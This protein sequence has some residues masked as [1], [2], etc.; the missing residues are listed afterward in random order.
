MNE[1]DLELEAEFDQNLMF[2]MIREPG[3]GTAG[4]GGDSNNSS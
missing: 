3:N 1:V 2:G 4:T